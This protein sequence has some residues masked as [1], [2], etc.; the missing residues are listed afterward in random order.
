MIYGIIKNN[1]L[2][3]YALSIKAIPSYYKYVIYNSLKEYNLHKY[4]IKK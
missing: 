1:K 4:N 3:G 2:I